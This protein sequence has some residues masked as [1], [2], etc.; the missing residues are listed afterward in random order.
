MNWLDVILIIILAGT[1]LG[2]LSRGLVVTVLGFAGFALGLKLASI[3]YGF[4]AAKL[5]FITSPLLA[6][7]LGFIV[8]WAG[9]IVLASVV[10]MIMRKAVSMAGL[11]ILDR[12]GGLLFGLAMGLFLCLLLVVAMLHF[13][14]IDLSEPI[15]QSKIASL[16][17][18]KL[19]IFFPLLPGDWGSLLRLGVR[20]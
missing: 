6:N 12:L 11:G 17:A 1:A 2:G 3:H 16:L 8:V 4:A 15:R 7:A 20:S 13:Q 5:T 19:A 18:S 10:G 14:A 9:V